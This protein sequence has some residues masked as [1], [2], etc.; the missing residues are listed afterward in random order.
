M[1]GEK[2]DLRALALVL[3]LALVGVST[4][5]A[6]PP[7]ETWHYMHYK[8]AIPLVLDQNIVAVHNPEGLPDET[9]EGYLTAVGFEGFVMKPAGRPWFHLVR[10]P[11]PGDPGP[12]IVGLITSAAARPD[13][14][15]FLS[16]VFHAPDDPDTL[17]YPSTGTSVGFLEDLP[18][19]SAEAELRR[20]GI[21]GEIL[22]RNWLRTPNIFRVARGTTSGLT[23]LRNANALASQPTVRFASPG[24]RVV[25]HLSSGCATASNGLP[26]DA[27]YEHYSW[28]R[29]AIG[30]DMSREVC[31]GDPQVIIAVLDDGVDFHPDLWSYQSATP[32]VSGNRGA[33]LVGAQCTADCYQGECNAIPCYAGSGVCVS[34]GVCS[35]RPQVGCDRHGTEVASV[36]SAALNNGIGTAGAAPAVSILP[37]KIARYVENEPAADKYGCTLGSESVNTLNTMDFAAG[38]DWAAA[39]GAHVT[40]L[41]WQ[42]GSSFSEITEA[43]KRT[44]ENDNVIHF[45]ASGN[46]AKLYPEP[47][48]GDSSLLTEIGPVNSV[49]GQNQDGSIWSNSSRGPGIDFTAPAAGIFLMDRTNDSTDISDTAGWCDS[50][51]LPTFVGFCFGNDPGVF[52]DIPPPPGGLYVELSGTSFAAPLVA[53]IAALIISMRPGISAPE[54][55]T[56]LRIYSDD[57]GPTGYDT[58]FGWGRPNAEKIVHALSGEYIF[59]DGFEAGSFG[60]WSAVLG[61]T[62]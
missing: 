26:N 52:P 9:V 55:E 4:A 13:N 27:F 36:I 25:G 24:F 34:S 38:I 44:Y 8:T 48:G 41:S 29:Q 43:Y 62:P 19:A 28:G 50:V 54:V 20:A 6:A 46:R 11:A 3:A 22:D 53:S 30:L 51:V 32:P 23:L 33:F 45:V 58:D 16:P 5:P 18:P 1:C 40:T 2:M 12:D 35:G 7:Q 57:F 10:E 61:G 15:F 17:I 31:I 14:P 37:V 60:A 56:I 59:A 47:P 21:V 49:S 42:T 39:N